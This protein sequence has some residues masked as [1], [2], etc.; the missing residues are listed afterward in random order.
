MN[1]GLERAA[2]RD[3]FLDEFRHRTLLIAVGALTAADGPDMTELRSTVAMLRDNG[4]RILLIAAGSGPG[5]AHAVAAALGVTCTDDLTLRGPDALDH[6]AELWMRLTDHGVVVVDAATVE[7]EVDPQ[8]VHLMVAAELA[9]ALRA[10]KLVLTDPLGGWGSPVRSFIHQ[11]AGVDIHDGTR[12]EVAA[13]VQAAL[14]GDVATV[15]LCRLDELQAELFTFDGVGTLFTRDAYLRVSPLTIDDLPMVEELVSRGVAEGFL[16]SRPRKEIVTI[17]LHGLGARI[18]RSGHLAAIGGLERR[19]YAADRVGEVTCLY[20]MS[21]FTG[22]GAAGYL[23]EGLVASAISH[24]LTAVFAC[25]VSDRAASFFKSQ[26]FRDVEQDRVP[27][28]KW[29]DYDPDRRAQVSVL[30]LDLEANQETHQE[31]NAEPL[32]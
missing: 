7:P 28:A 30:W 17:A 1:V 6:F 11:S 10:D 16:R 14:D 5:G 19:R 27:T 22:E 29:D 13:A 20:T 26:G 2:E 21:R 23:L 3:F 9:T 31:T 25:T 12:P 4:S 24:E 18:A 8:R 15:N 32:S